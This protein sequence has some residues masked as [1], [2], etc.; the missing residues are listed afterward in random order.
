MPK[1]TPTPRMMVPFMSDL[2][3]VAAI[4]VFI[5]G[6]PLFVLSEQTEQY[7]AWT[8]ASPLTAAFLGAAYWSSCLLEWLA[9]REKRWSNARIAVPAVLLFTGLTLVVTLLHLDRF[10]LFAQDYITKFVAWI[11]LVVYAVV[12]VL[13]GILLMVQLRTPGQE[14][15]K[16]EPFPQW[17]RVVLGIQA[18]V[19]AVLGIALLVVPETVAPLWPWA[20]TAL[21]GR[22][23]GAWLTAL[24][25][26]AAQ[27]AWENDYRRSRPAFFSYALLVVLQLLALARYPNEVAGSGFSLWLYLLFLLSMGVVAVATI[28]GAMQS[29]R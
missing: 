7:F 27:M 2:L 6:I 8:I 15:G 24:G 21:T 13:M 23:I 20:L 11:W 9:S 17:V 1:A 19:M 5:I 22:A 25:V 14:I 4:L 12:P 26:A 18:A 28:R 29:V 10:H 3:V 16:S